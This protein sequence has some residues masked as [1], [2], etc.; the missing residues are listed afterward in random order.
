MISFNSAST[1][2][3]FSII[4]IANTFSLFDN[5]M[6]FG[7][8]STSIKFII[9]AYLLYRVYQHY[10]TIITVLSPYCK[11]NSFGW[12]YMYNRS[13]STLLT[14]ISFIPVQY[15]TSNKMSIFK[16]VFALS[17]S[18]FAGMFLPLNNIPVPI[19]I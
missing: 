4:T 18:L 16:S 6:Q 15:I 3:K 2:H 1:S 12:A 11:W 17:N 10:L 8:F 9:I 5:I 13:N 7:R 14:I 19:P